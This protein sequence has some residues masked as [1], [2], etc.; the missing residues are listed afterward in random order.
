MPSFLAFEFPIQSALIFD[1]WVHVGFCGVVFTDISL[2]G[3]PA[4]TQSTESL[5]LLY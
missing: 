3:A 2:F 4:L 5:S 1:G